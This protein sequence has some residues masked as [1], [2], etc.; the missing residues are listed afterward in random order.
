MLDIVGILA[1]REVVAM[2]KGVR[3]EICELLMHECT[4]QEIAA[5]LGID[6]S[7]VSRHIARIRQAFIYAGF[8][9][10]TWRPKRPKRRERRSHTRKWRLRRRRKLLAQQCFDR[11]GGRIARMF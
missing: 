5:R 4:Q 9:A 7:S 10:W 11:M 6:Q 8:G 1:V 3:R 2:Q